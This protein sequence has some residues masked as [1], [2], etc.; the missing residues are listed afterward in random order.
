MTS[1]VFQSIVHSRVGTFHL[2]V[3]S[4]A[5]KTYCDCRTAHRIIGDR[6]MLLSGAI[7]AVA[8]HDF[9]ENTTQNNFGCHV[10][11]Y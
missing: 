6:E 11:S 9:T 10:F 4:G 8:R 7:M 5:V 2:G 1:A 3:N